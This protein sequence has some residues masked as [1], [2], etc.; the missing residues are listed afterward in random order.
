L[1]DNEDCDPKPVWEMPRSVPLYGIDGCD[2]FDPTIVVGADGVIGRLTIGLDTVSSPTTNT[3]W[4]V[5][6]SN[7]QIFYAVGDSGTIL[8]SIDGGLAWTVLQSPTSVDLVHVGCQSNTVY[9]TGD[10]LA[11]FRSTDGGITWTDFEF[12]GAF[13]SGVSTSVDGPPDLSTLLFVDD[14][15]G[16]AFGEF[17]VAFKTTEG[18]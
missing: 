9:I 6:C 8:K 12:Y 13:R 5:C 4:D 7:G 16:Y 18:G 3:L 15:T 11:G 17:G 2:P 14:S 1:F 10:D